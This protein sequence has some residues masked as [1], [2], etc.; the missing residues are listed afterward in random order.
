MAAVATARPT[1]ALG[2]WVCR[3]SSQ[4]KTPFPG[5][6]CRTQGLGSGGCCSF[7]RSWPRETG[8]RRPRVWRDAGLTPHLSGAGR[9]E[10]PGGG[11]AEE[12]AGQRGTLPPL[13]GAVRGQGAGPARGDRQACGPRVGQGFFLGSAMVVPHSGGRGRRGRGCRAA[14]GAQACVGSPLPASSG[15]PRCPHP[16]LLLGVPDVDGELRCGR[17]GGRSFDLADLGQ[18]G[19]L[20]AS[21]S[22]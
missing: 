18:A 19:P 2:G 17:L 16:L 4:R 14:G 20:P 5:W 12:G 11:G 6:P 1:A 22:G 9:P 3:G 21:K 8:H 15:L 7:P 10:V 13:R